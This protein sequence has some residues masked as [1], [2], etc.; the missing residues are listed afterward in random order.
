M[1]VGEFLYTNE[2]ISLFMFIPGS[3]I[4]GAKIRSFPIVNDA[5]CHLN[6]RL[7]TEEGICTLRNLLD[8]DTPSKDVSEFSK[9]PIFDLEM[10]MPMRALLRDLGIEE[11]L[12][13]DAIN[14]DS[15]F[16]DDDSVHLG[17]AVHRTHVKVTEENIVAGAVN[18]IYTGQENYHVPSSDSNQISQ[19][20][21]FPFVWLIYDKQRR[22][23]L[24]AGAF[25]KSC[26]LNLAGLGRQLKFFLE[27]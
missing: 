22:H 3:L 19:N 21:D 6:E 2:K 15:L 7:S 26:S 16:V 23:V 10:D 5:I 20:C 11:L 17:N 18:V 8:S 4:P 14:L 12:E 9:G 27:S 1:L 13:P 25:N 24:F